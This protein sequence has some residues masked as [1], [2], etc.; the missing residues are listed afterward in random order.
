MVDSC[1]EC[2]ACKSGEEQNC[3]KQVGTYGSLDNGSGRAESY[4]KGRQTLGGYTTRMVVDER[5]AIRIPESYP[6]EYAGPVMCAGITTYDPLKKYG[7]KKGSTVGIIGLGGL[8]QMG[9]KLAKVLGA[10]VT[11]VSRSDSKKAYALEIGA[12]EFIVSANPEQMLAG[13]GSLDLILNT[14]PSYHDYCEYNSLLKGC[15][16]QILLGLHK[17]IGAAMIMDQVRCG[18]SKVGMS[19]IGGVANTQEVIDLCAKHNIKPDVKVVP[20]RDLNQV[21]TLLDNG[22]AGNLRYVLDLKGTLTTET[23]DAWEDCEPPVLAEPEGAISVCAVLCECCWLFWC[24]K[25]C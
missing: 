6:L 20:V 2:S 22:G 25:T 16:K 3:S 1:Q 10:R 13:Q 5:F 17:G 24:C 11:V 8:G 4:P 15:G 14:I 21:Y 12:D 9:I 18:S 23:H 7:V 19:A